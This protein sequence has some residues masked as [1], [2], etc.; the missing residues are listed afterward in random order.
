MTDTI[1]ESTARTW[2][3]PAARAVAA[4]LVGLPVAFVEHTVTVA[5]VSVTVFFGLTA[6][7]TGLFAREAG[8]ASARFRVLAV[9]HAAAAIAALVLLFAAPEPAVFVVLVAAWAAASA[10]IEFSSRKLVADRR[11][12]DWTAVAVGTGAFALLVACSPLLGIAD[13]VSLTGFFGAFAAVAGVYLAIAAAS[14]AFGTKITEAS[15]GDTVEAQ[16]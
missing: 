8:A 5:F 6:I 3:L 4:L 11:S 7:A 14:L 1:D 16:P 12:N 2:R 10:V 9:V 13:P 15:A